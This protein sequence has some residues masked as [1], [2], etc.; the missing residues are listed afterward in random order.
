M[1][2]GTTASPWRYD[3]GALPRAPNGNGATACDFALRLVGAVFPMSQGGPA[4]RCRKVVRLPFGSGHADQSS[5]R[6]DASTTDS[7]KCLLGRRV[8][9]LPYRK[10][11][12]HD[13]SIQTFSLSTPN[14]EAV[15]L[16]QA[17][18]RPLLANRCSP[19]IGTDPTKTPTSR[20]KL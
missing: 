8:R 9:K 20:S 11:L 4:T 19:E 16:I 14:A 15:S 5:G 6:R 2:M 3:A 7:Q 17:S 1:K 18:A 12:P 10:A 13:I